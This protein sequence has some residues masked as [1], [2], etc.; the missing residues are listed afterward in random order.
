MKSR[1]PLPAPWL[2]WM[3]ELRYEWLPWLVFAALVVCVAMLFREVAVPENGSPPSLPLEQHR[4][5]PVPPPA[6][7]QPSNGASRLVSAPAR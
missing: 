5:S 2:L 1:W 4:L 3:R 6:P 7:P